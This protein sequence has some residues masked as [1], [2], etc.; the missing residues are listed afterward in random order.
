MNNNELEVKIKIGEIEFYAKGQTADVEAQR[1]N[2][3]NIILPAAV[4]AIKSSKMSQE[5]IEEAQ[6]PVIAVTK[7]DATVDVH[8]D[9]GIMSVNEFIKSKGFRTQE[10]IAIGLIYYYEIYKNIKVFSTEELKNYFKE[11]KNT[12]PGNPSMIVKRL[13]GKGFI[14]NGDDKKRFCLTQTGIDYVNNYAPKETKA[15]SLER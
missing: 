1:Q 3:T 9:Q 12:L 8:A 10:D 14:M 5:Y 13:F 11:S 2:F 7:E 4:D 15:K 6:L